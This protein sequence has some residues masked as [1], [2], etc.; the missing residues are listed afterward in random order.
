[1]LRARFI[2]LI[3]L[4]AGCTCQRNTGAAD[5]G[6]LPTCGAEL[7]CAPG[8]VCVS[9]ACQRSGVFDGSTACESDRECPAGKQCVRSTGQCVDPVDAGVEEPDSGHAGD[10]FDG[11]VLSCG[12]SKLG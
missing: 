2:A 11:Q 8:W 5:G 7:E 6:E 9:G 12:S 1:M 4:A 3:C 10:C